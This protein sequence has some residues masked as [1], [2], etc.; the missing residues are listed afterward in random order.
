MIK[1]AISLALVLASVALPSPVTAE[2]TVRS[3]EPTGPFA[4]AI[5]R[6][7]LRLALA[8]SGGSADVAWARVRKLEAGREISLTMRGLP[9]DTRVFVSADDSVITVLNLTDLAL[10]S[11]AV[12]ALREIT[13]QHREYLEGAAKGGIVLSNKVRLESGAVFVAGRKVADLQRVVE[14]WA[15]KDVAEITTRQKGRGVWGHLGALGGYFVGAMSG[16]Y[17]AGFACRFAGDRDCD[18]AAG[19]GMLVGAIGG[20][21]YGFHAARRETEI[22]TYSTVQ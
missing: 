18:S 3:L 2:E 10:P 1:T 7:G 4:R 19:V 12:R 21:A 15:R 14:T 13:S 16:G 22:V 11:T 9:E 6:E 8:P 5:M 20:G 17:I